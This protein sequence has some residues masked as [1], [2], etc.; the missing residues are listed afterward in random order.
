MGS[1]QRD[2]SVL[3]PEWRSLEVGFRVLAKIRSL[4][5]VEFVSPQYCMLRPV[6]CSSL[7]SVQPS[8]G[9]QPR[10]SAVPAVTR[11]YDR[12]RGNEFSST[13]VLGAPLRFLG[14]TRRAVNEGPTLTLQAWLPSVPF[15]S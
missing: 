12:C 6:V 8:V 9:I 10:H 14:E 5:M 4:T 1:V 15:R 11:S 2:V 3:S 13:R 7:F